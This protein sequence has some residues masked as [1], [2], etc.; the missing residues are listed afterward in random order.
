MLVG[1]TWPARRPDTEIKFIV[2]III[3]KQ[4]DDLEVV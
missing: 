4:N 1:L 3:N 2:I